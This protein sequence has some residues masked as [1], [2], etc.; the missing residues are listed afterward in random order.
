MVEFLKDQ[1]TILLIV[2]IVFGAP[3]LFIVC[4]IGVLSILRAFN[5]FLYPSQEKET[6]FEK[7]TE[8]QSSDT[9]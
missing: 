7:T 3:S 2:L 8:I 1:F 9:R 4:F 5:N 6:T